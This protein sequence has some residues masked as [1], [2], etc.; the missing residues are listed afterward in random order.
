MFLKDP[1]DCPHSLPR[2]TWA[3]DYPRY[4][5]DCIGPRP[6]KFSQSNNGTPAGTSECPHIHPSTHSLVPFLLPSSPLSDS[7]TS[8]P[9]P[10][11]S[12]FLSYYPL[13]TPGGHPGCPSVC[14]TLPVLPESTPDRSKNAMHSKWVLDV[15][16]C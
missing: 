12:V 2:S 8:A 13:P 7:P 3:Q 11:N 1:C 9:S 5:E 14:L 6:R 15:Q 4:E 10:L 16:S